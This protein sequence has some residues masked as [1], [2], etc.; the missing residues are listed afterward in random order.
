MY[1]DF[2]VLTVKSP[3]YKQVHNCAVLNESMPE[4]PFL[5]IIQMNSLKSL[6]LLMHK[7]YFHTLDINLE[8]YMSPWPQALPSIKKEAAFVVWR[9][10]NGSWCHVSVIGWY[11]PSS[12]Q[13]L[14][15]PLSL[16]TGS[17]ASWYDGTKSDHFH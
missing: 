16:N 2:S 10:L 12:F 9:D 15:S 3:L 1:P 14:Y 4:P 5:P 11:T 8:F 13:W 17:L 7:Q 6:I